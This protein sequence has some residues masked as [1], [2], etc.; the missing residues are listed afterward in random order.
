MWFSENYQ[1]TPADWRAKSDLLSQRW[2]FHNTIGALDRKHVTIRKT[3]YG[4]SMF[5]N[6]KKY[7]SIVL[8]ALAKINY[9]LI[10]VDMGANGACADSHI[11]NRII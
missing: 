6:Y 4:G 2:N 5:Y 7:H 3:A 8:L 1:K 9:E 10:C 11:W